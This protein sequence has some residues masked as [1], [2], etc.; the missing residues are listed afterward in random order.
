MKPLLRGAIVPA[1]LLVLWELASRWGL[2]LDTLSRPSDIALA[3][4]SS[5]RDGSILIATMQTF[6]S[7]LWGLA[8]A[9]VIGILV[10]SLLGLSP[11]LEG[12]TGRPSRR[13]ARSRPSPSCRTP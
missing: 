6:E 3:L 4:L 1:L 11:M 13:C 9:A 12:V 10:G 5:L 8:I 7:A 2:I